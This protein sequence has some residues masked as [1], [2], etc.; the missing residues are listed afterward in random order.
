MTPGRNNAVPQFVG[1]TANGVALS[2]CG[3]LEGH[4]GVVEVIAIG[5]GG[6]AVAMS[7]GGEFGDG[8]ACS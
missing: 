1:K 7:H 3:V 8:T 5:A 2:H 4:E 6:N